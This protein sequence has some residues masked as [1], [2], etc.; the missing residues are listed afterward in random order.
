MEFATRRW[1]RGFRARGEDR[2]VIENGTFVNNGEIAPLIGMNRF[3]LLDDRITRRKRGLSGE[4]RALPLGDPWGQTRNDLG[5]APWVTTD[6][7]INTAADQ[8]PIAPGDKVVDRVAN[9][10]R[11]ARFVSRTPILLF[12][13][14]QSARYAETRGE[15]A[16]AD[17]RRIPLTVF[18]HPDHGWNAPRM[19]S[20]MQKSLA[21][22]T[23][24]FGPYQFNHARII[25]FPA[26]AEFAQAFAGTVPYS[27]GIGF[28]ANTADADKIDYVTY[29][30]AHELGHQYWGHQIVPA[31]TQGAS[32]VVE[33][34]AQYSALMVMKQIYG[35]DKMR[36]FLKYE[37]DSYLFGRGGEAIEELP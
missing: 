1:N 35:P 34:M 8:T 22:F 29:I 7:I 20:A 16:L 2:S 14:M 11:T 26:Y 6:I 19:I 33:T 10:R 13:S 12:L 9:G 21:Y 27:E 37:L 30:T 17:G 28:L 3:G 31:E 18:H 24:N 15:A 36:R 23:R 32:F 4:L 5:N 25:E